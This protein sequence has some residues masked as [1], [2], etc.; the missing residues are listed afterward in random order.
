MKER[1]KP[2]FEA[3][4]NLL[5]NTTFRLQ[6]QKYTKRN[7]ARS[8]SL[9]SPYISIDFYRET[10]VFS[11]TIETIIVKYVQ[12]DLFPSYP[13][14]VAYFMPH[15][16]GFIILDGRIVKIIID[17]EKE[18]DYADF[19]AFCDMGPVWEICEILLAKI[20]EYIPT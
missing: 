12:G 3:H 2:C 11:V 4:R 1:D 13:G 5:R 6:G 18:Y 19:D 7:G 10:G 9:Q 17:D 8:V 20:G 14:L 15:N 16:L